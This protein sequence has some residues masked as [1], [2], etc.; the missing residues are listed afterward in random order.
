MK[1]AFLCV[2]GILSILVTLASAATK[3]TEHTFTGTQ[4]QVWEAVLTAARGNYVITQVDDKHHIVTFEQGG[5]MFHAEIMYNAVV[6]PEK[7]GKVV[8]SLNHQG[9]KGKTIGGNLSGHFFD[10]VAEALA[11]QQEVPSKK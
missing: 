2:A 10:R 9:M 7:D 1:K 11:Q 8:V 6:E 4:D 3:P 5:G